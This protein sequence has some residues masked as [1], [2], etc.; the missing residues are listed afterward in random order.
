MQNNNKVYTWLFLFCFVELYSNFNYLVCIVLKR[1]YSVIP[2]LDFEKPMFMARWDPSQ[3]RKSDEMGIQIP[4]SE[5]E[6]KL[7]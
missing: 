3:P 7:L 2:V 1:F 6:L 5:D 4:E